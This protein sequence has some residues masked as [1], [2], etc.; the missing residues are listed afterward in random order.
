MRLAIILAEYNRPA[1]DVSQYRECWPDA[2][3][4]VYTELPETPELDPSHPRYGWRMNDYWKVRKCLDALEAGA[5]VAISFDSDMWIC[6]MEAARTLPDLAM[7]FGL[8][9]PL[10]PRYTV[11]RDF[12]DGADVV[13]STNQFLWCGP[14]MNCSPVAICT[15]RTGDDD[16]F[17]IAE[18]YCELMLQQ[19]QR[20]P[21]NWW[22]A[23]VIQGRP[24]LILPP[25]WCV[26]ERHIGIGEEIILH[27]GHEAVKRHYGYRRVNG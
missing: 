7:R 16:G 21:M 25:H 8:C 18:K 5:D 9:L 11:K 12:T 20:G 2:D 1:P 4:Q 6:D 14:S 27:M 23:A 13:G 10:N 15:R 19:P 24:P 17:D 22:H 3:I 26:C